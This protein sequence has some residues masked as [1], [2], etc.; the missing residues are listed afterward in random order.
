MLEDS[1]LLRG[2]A[3]REASQ[4]GGSRL[5]KTNIFVSDFIWIILAVAI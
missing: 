5:I 4:E 3:Q 2:C 1:S